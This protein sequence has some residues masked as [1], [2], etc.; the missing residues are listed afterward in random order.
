[1]FES[2]PPHNPKMKNQ[3][4]QLL[5]SELKKTSAVNDVALWRRIADE[6]E[7]P[8]KKRAALNL[9][10]IDKMVKQDEIALVPG[11][12][13]SMGNLSKKITIAAY[14]FSSHAQEK[15]KA[16]GSKAIT[17]YDLVKKNPKGTN[18]RILK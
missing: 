2:R 4:L 8:T 9:S 7:A 11:K 1:M 17:I 16:S 15:I 3:K 5:I 10:K 18:I 12:V 13:L 14:T 6:L